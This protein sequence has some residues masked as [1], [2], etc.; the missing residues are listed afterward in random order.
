MEFVC[1]NSGIIIDNR[2][3]LTGFGSSLNVYLLFCSGTTLFIYLFVLSGLYL[4]V[5]GEI[6][7]YMT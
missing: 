7:L 4:Q 2:L 5:V 6:F 3:D 1:Y